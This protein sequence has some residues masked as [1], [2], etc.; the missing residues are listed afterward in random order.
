M[1]LML[2]FSCSVAV[3]LD[4][5]GELENRASPRLYH[6]H[7]PFHMLPDQVKDGKCKVCV[8]YKINSVKSRE[9]CCLC[10]VDIPNVN[11][12]NKNN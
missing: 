6:T 9:Y 11:V 5:M 3:H 4:T 7:L 10:K 8:A 1:T 12:T 2:I